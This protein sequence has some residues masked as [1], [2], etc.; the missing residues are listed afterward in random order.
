MFRVSFFIFCLSDETKKQIAQNQYQNEKKGRYDLVFFFYF[1]LFRR[2]L[3]QK[4][5][6]KK[7]TTQLDITNIYSIKTVE[8][9]YKTQTNKQV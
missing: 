2:L 7:L 1:E 4:Q 8:V 6:T 5:K 9:R 3:L